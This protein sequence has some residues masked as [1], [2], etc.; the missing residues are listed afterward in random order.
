M[1]DSPRTDETAVG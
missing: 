1:N